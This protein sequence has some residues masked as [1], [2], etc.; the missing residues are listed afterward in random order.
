M[1]G[2]RSLAIASAFTV[3]AIFGL[4]SVASSH[5]DDSCT[6]YDETSAGGCANCMKREWTG[7]DWRFVDICTAGYHAPSP[8]HQET[9]GR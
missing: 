2:F 4:T 5:P 9:P 6:R 8:D 1:K 3:A 7:H